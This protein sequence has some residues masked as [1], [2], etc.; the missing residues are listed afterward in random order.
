VLTDVDV[1]LLHAVAEG[2]VR[3]KTASRSNACI[4]GSTYQLEGIFSAR[5]SGDVRSASAVRSGR[6]MVVQG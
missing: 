1:L 6:S 3:A 4:R 5:A 2:H